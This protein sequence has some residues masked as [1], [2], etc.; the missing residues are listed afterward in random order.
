MKANA[1]C[2]TP[3]HAFTIALPSTDNRPSSLRGICGVVVVWFGCGGVV[4]LWWC[5]LVVVVW[6]GCG[7]VVVVKIGCGVVV[8]MV[9]RCGVVWWCGSVWYGLVLVWFGCVC[10]VVRCGGVC[11]FVVVWLCL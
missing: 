4:W 9:W 10:G 2:T 3:A 5:G 7:G 11:G 1:L 6:F 8:F